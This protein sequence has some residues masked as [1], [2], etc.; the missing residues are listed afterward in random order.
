MKLKKDFEAL[1]RQLS[2][3]KEERAHGLLYEDQTIQDILKSPD[4]KKTS[5]RYQKKIE[6]FM[7][8]RNLN[9]DLKLLTNMPNGVLPL[10]NKTL[11]L[12]K[13]K[14]TPFK[15]IHPVA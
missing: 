15:P 13:Q 8:K 5:L 10:S 2:L 1:S 11:N 3:W 7:R 14:P 4:N 9:A 6:R 12:L